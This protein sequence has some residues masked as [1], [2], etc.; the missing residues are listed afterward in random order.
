MMETGLLEIVLQHGRLYRL[1]NPEVGRRPQ[2]EVAL[3]FVGSTSL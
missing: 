1:V 3:A 2:E